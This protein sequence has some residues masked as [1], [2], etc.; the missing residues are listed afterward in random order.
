MNGM[1]GEIRKGDNRMKKIIIYMVVLFLPPA[2]WAQDIYA[3]ILQEIEQ[4]STTLQALKEG[5]NATKLANKTGLMPDNPEVEFGYLWGNPSAI[6]NRK[7]ISVSQTLDFPTAYI[8]RNRLSELQNHSAE[9]EYRTQRMELLLS[10]KSKCIELVYYNALHKLYARQAEQANRI[11]EAHEKM[12]QAGETNRLAY[13]KAMLNRTNMT[14]ELRRIDLEGQH[15][16]ST[17]ATMNGGKEV[18]FVFDGYEAVMLPADFENW[19]RTAEMQNPSLQYLRSQVDVANCQV[20][21]SR[22]EGMPKF[23]VGYTGEYVLGEKFQ[24][25]TMG[26]SI[27]LWQNKNR[28]K[29]AQAA[30]TT[31]GIMK[32][33]AKVQYYNR[34]KALYTE[35]VTLQATTCEYTETLKNHG[36]EELLLKAY[37][38]GEL[39]LLEYLLEMEY[40]Y[41]CYKNKM[42]AERDLALT[43]A[44]LTAYTL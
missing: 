9:Y 6:G 38:S 1:P 24:G 44:N 33:D 21:V 17:L 20:S 31:S 14:N 37:H 11:A 12:M 39:S 10:A 30:A 18:D 43:F 22:A 29:H 4:N 2:V 26:I 27:P 8:W 5:L 35:A 41:A 42:E 3:P 40:Y 32:E 16:L 15:L 19:Y 23:S 34:L 7:E 36:S 25:I 28:I 13:N